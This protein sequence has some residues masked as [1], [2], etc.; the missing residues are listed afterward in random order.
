MRKR[1]L[2][3][4]A[5]ALIVGCSGSKVD[6]ADWKA[7][8]AGLQAY[9][10]KRDTKAEAK[11]KEAQVDQDK[12]TIKFSLKFPDFH[13]ISTTRDGKMAKQGGKWV[14]TEVIE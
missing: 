14:V 1:M 3:I 6:P 7:L 4:A 13:S 12:A 11:L 8:D 9:W 5:A 2:L 10:H